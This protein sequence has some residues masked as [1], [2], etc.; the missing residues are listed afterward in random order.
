MRIIEVIC[1]AFTTPYYLMTAVDN[2]IVAGCVILALSPLV[3]LVLRGE[4]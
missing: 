1:H 2:L 3:R 4:R